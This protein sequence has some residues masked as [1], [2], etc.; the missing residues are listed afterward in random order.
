[1]R[2]FQ[3]AWS[4]PGNTV[5]GIDKR[6]SLNGQNIGIPWVSCIPTTGPVSESIKTWENMITKNKALAVRRLKECIGNAL[7]RVAMSRA[8]TRLCV[9]P[10]WKRWGFLAI[11]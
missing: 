11:E 2:R 3:V 1:M 8:N 5:T 7:S 6:Y 10:E 4:G 9:G